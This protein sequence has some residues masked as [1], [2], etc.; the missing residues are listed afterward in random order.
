MAI[1]KVAS[2]Q[3]VRIQ[4]NPDWVAHIAPGFALP[5]DLRVDCGLPDVE[6]QK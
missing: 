4:V 3:A 5:S 6:N 1:G 2:I